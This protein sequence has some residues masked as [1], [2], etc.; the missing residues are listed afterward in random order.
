MILLLDT[1][2]AEC[3]TWLIDGDKSETVL[4]Q[5]DR[6]LS[7]LL[8]RHLKDTLESRGY[9]W[10]DI[11]GIGIFRGPGSFTGLRIGMTVLNTLS[12]SERIPIVGGEGSDW[13]NE[14]LRK[15]HSGQDEKI[16][17]PYYG[18]DA[19]VTKPRK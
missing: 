16:V 6:D 5:A 14:V 7:R 12:D 3:R 13:Q 9:S 2:T 4:W 19:N 17:L 18:R 1:S 8:L 10:S 15:L 11:D